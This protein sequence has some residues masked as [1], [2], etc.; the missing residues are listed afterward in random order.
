MVADSLLP[1][2]LI[3]E[4]SMTILMPFSV[5]FLFPAACLVI[6]IIGTIIIS[7]SPWNQTKECKE[8]DA[9]INQDIGGVG[10]L[11]GLFLPC[12]VLLFVLGMGHF[13]SETSGPKELCMAQLA[14]LLYLTINIGKAI[15]MKTINNL[16]LMIAFSSID[17]VNAS[18]SMAFSDKDVL[19]ARQL[20]F[21]GSV[22][23]LAA[24]AVEG[25]ALFNLSHFKDPLCISALPPQ[26]PSH[27]LSWFYWASRTVAAI[28]QILAA[29]N[30]SPSLNTI[31]NRSKESRSMN[32]TA[33]VFWLDLP[34]TITTSY[35][36]FFSFV[37]FHG[38][39][40]LRTTSGIDTKNEMKKAIWSEWGQTANFIVAVVSIS[41]VLYSI[42]RLFEPKDLRENA[43]LAETHN[44]IPYWGF[45]KTSWKSLRSPFR[46]PNLEHLDEL[47][48]S[49]TKLKN[50][51]SPPKAQEEKEREREYRKLLEAYRK[52]DEE[53]MIDALERG[54]PNDMIGPDREYPI[55]MAARFNN[56]RLLKL[57]RFCVSDPHSELVHS[58][59]SKLSEESLFIKNADDEIPLMIAIHASAIQSIEWILK[60]ME[61]FAK[62]LRRETEVEDLVRQAFESAIMAEKETIIPVL[63]IGWLNWPQ[64]KLR[65]N[66][67]DD[68]MSSRVLS[69]FYF[70]IKNGKERVTQLLCDQHITNLAVTRN[71][72]GPNNFQTVYAL[73]QKTRST[74][75]VKRTLEDQSHDCDDANA[76]K[77][78]LSAFKSFYLTERDVFVLLSGIG[79][80]EIVTLFQIAED[81]WIE[82]SKRIWKIARIMR[83]DDL[84][85]ETCSD[86]ILTLWGPHHESEN[87][88]D[89]DEKLMRG[90]RQDKMAKTIRKDLREWGGRDWWYAVSGAK[91][92]NYGVM[93]KALP[94]ESDVNDMNRIRMVRDQYGCSLLGIAI[95]PAS[96]HQGANDKD[97]TRAT[98]EEGQYE[99]KIKCIETLIQLKIPVT[100]EDILIAFR[101][102]V[103]VRVFEVL[104]GS[105]ED[106]HTEALQ[107][108]CQGLHM[109]WN[110]DMLISV[111]M[112]RYFLG[113]IDMLLQSGADPTRRDSKGRTPRQSIELGSGHSTFDSI[114]MLGLWTDR[115]EGASY[116]DRIVKLLARWEH[117]HEGGRQQR[118]NKPDPVH[119]G[120]KEGEL[121]DQEFEYE[122]ELRDLVYDDTEEEDSATNPR[123]RN[124]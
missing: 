102:R 84:L 41:H 109:Y 15:P 19:A 105:A 26:L 108:C 32:V 4:S 23:Q 88:Y 124:P 68:R 110:L 100:A 36:L 20:V 18:V 79:V 34:A 38:S 67:D 92:G 66:L 106:S 14:N 51:L 9:T 116:I 85:S 65:E 55:H 35:W 91:V 29:C 117:Y 96:L 27:E 83:A 103:G 60:E 6:S 112:G 46:K 120:M 1:P 30:L 121:T 37:L 59:S 87:N 21:W 5:R 80:H 2:N 22:V 107:L 76:A 63:K 61:G 119:D 56:I 114:S 7:R 73:A 8:H 81:A 97:G 74:D 31:E 75:L 82:A 101:N 13:K 3:G 25:L 39:L 44:G 69:P 10:V 86:S 113:G 48:V 49:D 24:F 104:L 95:N 58:R 43:E 62:I 122:E 70:S 53:G 12:L 71:M 33:R 42:F 47:L 54:A 40:V 17:A 111:P 64:L 16:E 72:Q 123:M 90:I 94:K 50:A 93:M 89:D 99:E 45:L 118:P 57:A 115:H 28:F 11:I 98:L 78:V 52:R 77:L